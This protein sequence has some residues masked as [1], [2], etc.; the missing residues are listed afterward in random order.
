MGV[1]NRALK[2]KE[3][4]KLS[5]IVCVFDQSVFT[6]KAELNGGILLNTSCSLLLGT[7]HAIMMYMSVISKRFKDAELRDVLI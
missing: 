6:K 2:M 4:L 7:L 5:W 1:M 3:P